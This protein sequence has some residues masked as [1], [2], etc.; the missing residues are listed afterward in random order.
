MFKLQKSSSYISSSSPLVESEY[1]EFDIRAHLTYGV[2]TSAAAVAD[3]FLVGTN[4]GSIFCLKLGSLTP[5]S[6][7]MN[8]DN[9]NFCSSVSV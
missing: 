5:T 2:I 6:P 7:G 8:Y 1:V 9:V 3:S 4:T